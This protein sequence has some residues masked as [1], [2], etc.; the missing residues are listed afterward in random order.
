MNNIITKDWHEK[1]L[2]IYYSKY[3]CAGLLKLVWLK[4]L[5]VNI[6]IECT[7]NWSTELEKRK[8]KIL[9]VA[10]DFKTIYTAIDKCAVLMVGKGGDIGHVGVYVD[11]DT[12]YIL[13]SNK[14]F[15]KSILEPKNQ[16]FK[17]NKLVMYKSWEC[18]ND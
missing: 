16:V 7:F 11:I 6:D 18:V 13:H 15:K 17:T 3:N 14:D 8:N 10:K 5:N 4:E 12:G 9:S 1:Y 2:N